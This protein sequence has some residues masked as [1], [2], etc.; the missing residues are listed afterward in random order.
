MNSNPSFDAIK[1]FANIV[2]L[3]RIAAIVANGARFDKTPRQCS[4]CASLPV[5][6]PKRAVP[7]SCPRC[8]V[9]AYRSS[10]WFECAADPR[11][12]PHGDRRRACG[13]PPSPFP[14]NR[15]GVSREFLGAN[16]RGYTISPRAPYRR[17]E[18]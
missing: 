10:L 13:S 16:I 1:F 18:A 8:E 11:P 3:L 9:A 15:S 4:D 14:R 17:S 6:C 2:Y 7:V 5:R 12:V